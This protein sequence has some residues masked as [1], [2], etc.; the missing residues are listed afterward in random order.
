[1]DERI[2][3]PVDAATQSVV[4][5]IVRYRQPKRVI[6]FGS[7]GRGDPRQDSDIDLCVI[8]DK[9]GKPNVE[10]MQ[11]LYLDLFKH[12]PHPVDL[13]VYD[14]AVF[15][16]RSNRRNSFE[17]V[18]AT[19]GVIVYGCDATPEGQTPFVTTCSGLIPRASAILRREDGRSLVDVSSCE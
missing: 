15:V 18:I 19:E 3:S 2:V 17:S 6:L 7:R 8:Y 9:M 14:E 5:R 12:M 11:E 1:M 4:D 13:V 16:E 10:V